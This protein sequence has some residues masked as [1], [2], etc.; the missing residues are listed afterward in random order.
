MYAFQFQ[1]G[2]WRIDFMTNSRSP[3]PAPRTE[4]YDLYE[5]SYLSRRAANAAIDKIRAL[6]SDRSP[7]T[8][9]EVSS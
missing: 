7:P 4:A 6:A 1:D 3:R 5:A 8:S 2:S 9:E